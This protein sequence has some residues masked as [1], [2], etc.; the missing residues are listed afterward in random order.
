MDLTPTEEDEERLRRW[1]P[2]VSVVDR[3]EGEGRG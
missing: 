2:R 1:I 3:R